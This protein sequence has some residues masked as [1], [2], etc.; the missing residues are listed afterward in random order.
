ML[1]DVEPNRSIVVRPIPVCEGGEDKVVI[2]VEVGLT[3]PVVGDPPGCR[4]ATETL[5]ISIKLPGRGRITSKKQFRDCQT[6]A[7]T[8]PLISSYLRPW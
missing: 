4:E 8:Q 5:I 3:V 6:I 2:E 7:K 1:G